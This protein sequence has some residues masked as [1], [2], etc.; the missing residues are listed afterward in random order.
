MKQHQQVPSVSKQRPSG[1]R[2]LFAATVGLI[3]ALSGCSR[4]VATTTIQPNGSWT[5]VVSI[6]TP[7]IDMNSPGPG[8][9]KPEDVFVLP[10]G[11]G[12]KI[13]KSVK[14]SDAIYTA[15]RTVALGDSVSGDISIKK[16]KSPTATVVNQV[17]V[18]QVAP[19]KY[20][21]TERFT[22]KGEKPKELLQPD[23]DMLKTIKGALPAALATDA[24]ATALSVPISRSFW[25]MMFGPGEP[26]ISSFSQLMM[27]PEIT[28]RRVQKR[29]SAD[30][31]RVLADKFA[32][33][34][35]LDQRKSVA[36]KIIHT[37]LADT[38]SKTQN[39]PP[40]AGDSK[41]P[42]DVNPVTLSIFVKMPGQVT[43]SNGEIDG[44]EV[45]WSLYPQAAALG[46][47]TLTATCE[48]K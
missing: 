17:T 12:W 48:T 45:F 10:S 21:Y 20:V 30:V 38:N 27:E 15:E 42:G 26:I 23:P 44:N 19:G 8:D 13:T 47:V 6:H 3:A 34:L 41:P 16:D 25:R 2:I 18:K 11:P 33:R 9:V 29:M 43:E 36:H 7:K 37:L 28:E 4:E 40:G 5:R 14:E 1:Q 46:D 22:W 32:D 39:G 24:N 31:E 35:T